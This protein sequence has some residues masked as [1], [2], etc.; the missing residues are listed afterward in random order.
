MYFPREPNGCHGSLLAVR[1]NVIVKILFG[2]TLCSSSECVESSYLS[3]F[4]L[5]VAFPTF[6]KSPQP[7]HET[8]PRL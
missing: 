2:P 6:G 3:A 7:F 8:D 5:H 4:E 1:P